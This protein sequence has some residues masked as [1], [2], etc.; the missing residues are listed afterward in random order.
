[1]IINLVSHYNEIM[2]RCINKISFIS[3]YKQTPT[4]QNAFFCACM[5]V[6]GVGSGVL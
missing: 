2:S 5:P 6:S 1:M 4:T 3:C